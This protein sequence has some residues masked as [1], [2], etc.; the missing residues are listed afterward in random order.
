[1]QFFYWLL[2]KFGRWSSSHN[3]KEFWARIMYN[4]PGG[5][6]AGAGIAGTMWLTL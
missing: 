4:A 2:T 5:L 6:H 3:V 1:M